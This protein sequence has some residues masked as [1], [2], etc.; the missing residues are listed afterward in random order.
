MTDSAE[1]ITQKPRGRRQRRT[2]H[3]MAALADAIAGTLRE[4]GTMTVRQIFYR[5]V[6]SAIIDKT[7]LQYRAVVRVVTELRRARK[8][9]FSAIADNTRW[10]HRPASF[11]GLEEALRSC[12]DNYRRD[13][14]QD[15]PLYVEAWLEKDA[16]AGL[17][18][19][20]TSKYDV[21]LMVTRG[22]PSLTFLHD[23]AGTIAQAGRPA[24]LLYFGDWDPSGLDITRTV[25][26]G[27]KEFAGDVDVALT[28]VA[29]TEQQIDAYALPTR[30]TKASDPRS[31]KFD[32][33]S[34][35]LDA[36]P[37][38]Q[39]RA[40]VAH[41][42]RSQIDQRIWR[43]SEKADEADRQKLNGLVSRHLD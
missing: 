25:E 19:A 26:D 24:R 38:R 30:P 32:G 9:P 6:S 14:W 16:L 28:R 4:E 20:E 40:I 11:T 42:L 29:I 39:L 1:E 7:E 8:I 43:R 18:Y 33:D 17:V 15:Q 36:L 5:L 23:A 31:H 21:P 10:M 27:I 2:K 22:F 35:E 13:P 3:N 37:P 34:V 12:A 41:A